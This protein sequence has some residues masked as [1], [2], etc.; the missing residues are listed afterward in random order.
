MGRLVDDL[1]NLA[2]DLVPKDSAPHFGQLLLLSHKSF[3]SAITLI[4][5]AQPEDAAAV[6]RRAIEIARVA[7]AVKQDPQN[8]DKWMAHEK[9]MGR[10]QAREKGE[11]P[12]HLTVPLDLPNDHPILKELERHLGILSDA[13]IHFTPEFF[14]SQDWKRSQGRIDLRY[15][16]SDPKTIRRD[17]VELTG[18]HV[19]A[20]RIFDECLG[21][22]FSKSSEW[23]NLWNT[24]KKEG[25]KL[26]EEFAPTTAEG[27]SHG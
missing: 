13:Y 7:L 18:V 4:G 25:G 1:Y 19:S 5:Q 3:L 24:L 23:L 20:L 16:T 27:G 9:R 11:K 26:S 17:L 8:A 21:G 12:R 2:V 10:W 14:G 6:T 15:F 22:P